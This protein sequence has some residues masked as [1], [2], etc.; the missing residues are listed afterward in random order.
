MFKNWM[1]D[2]K[3]AIQA[4]S[5][6]TPALLVWAG[7]VAV[8]LMTAF[9]FLALAAYVWL[10]PQIGPVYAG[11]VMAGVFLLIALIGAIAAAMTR[12]RARER[13]MLERAARARAT[14]WL[15]DPK[16]I[17]AAMQAGRSL[18]W[19]RFIPL[20]LF[21]FLAAQWLRERRAPNDDT[22]QPS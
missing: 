10:L 8:A 11:L 17:G 16:I 5:G 20:A 1:R 9:S 21:G 18:G 14:P 7:I 15:L 2:I 4:N 12:R 3:L 19:E 6:F 13:A 22:D